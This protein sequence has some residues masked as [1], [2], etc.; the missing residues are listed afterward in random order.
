MI[1]LDAFDGEEMGVDVKEVIVD[2]R[3]MDVL[4]DEELSVDDDL[5][6][7]NESVDPRDLY[8]DKESVAAIFT[9][10]DAMIAL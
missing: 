7:V 4:D 5:A 8:T 6:V 9:A 2:L 1:S 10:V 3:V